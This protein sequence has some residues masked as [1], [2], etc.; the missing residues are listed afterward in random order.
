MD[1]RLVGRVID[2][3]RTVNPLLSVSAAVLDLAQPPASGSVRAQ[4]AARLADGSFRVLIDGRALRLALPADIKPGDVLQLRVVG[5]EAAAVAQANPA[6]SAAGTGV[7][8]AGQLVADLVRL[9]PTAPARQ[10]QPALDTPPQQARTLAEPLARAVERSGLFYESH[11][12]RW[13]RG[14]YPLERLLHEPQAGAGRGASTQAA[15]AAMPDDD[16][17]S[18]PDMPTPHRSSLAAATESE[19]EAEQTS[20][21]AAVAQDGRDAGAK[22]SEKATEMVARD[23]IDIVRQQLDALETRH[24]Q[25]LGEVWPGQPMRWEIGEEG[26]ER[27]EPPD[28]QHAWDSRFALDLPALG[29]VGADLVLSGNR[30]RLRVSAEEADTVALM[31]AAAQELMHALTAA[32]IEP[33]SFEVEQREPSL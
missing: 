20:M 14:E 4:V 1:A 8:S 24:F 9:P 6:A 18:K 23:A 26:G 30:L 11:Q 28:A 31:R 13:V 12:A 16:T 29:S 15:V 25:W 21:R 7:S 2:A 32:G 19:T 10:S 33:W 27:D 5:R 3:V 22:L 17:P